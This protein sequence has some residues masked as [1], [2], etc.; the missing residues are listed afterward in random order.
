MGFLPLLIIIAI[1]SFFIYR[2]RKRKKEEKTDMVKEASI[3]AGI[4]R[5][6]L[7][8]IVLAI[9]SVVVS[10]NADFYYNSCG[11]VRHNTELKNALLY[12][13]LFV[14]LIGAIMAIVSNPFTKPVEKG[15]G[16][17][18]FCSKCGSQYNESES[19]SFCGKCGTKL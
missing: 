8:M 11:V 6:G 15:I 18:K 12:G 10:Q 17:L 19:K 16:A 1:T 7:I 3:K 13:G 4:F 14:G 2:A 5:A 9:I